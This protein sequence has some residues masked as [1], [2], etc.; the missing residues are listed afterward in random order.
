[1]NKKDR[2]FQIWKRNPLNVE[3]SSQK[4]FLQK[5][6]YIHYN[7]VEAGLTSYPEAYHYSSAS[8]YET[9]VDHFKML[10]H[11]MG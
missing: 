9:G 5:M 2:T 10:T 6:E 11:Y 8:F 4:V 3:L 7:P 1:V